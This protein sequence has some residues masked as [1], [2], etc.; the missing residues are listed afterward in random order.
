MAEAGRTL[1]HL[2]RQIAG[3]LKAAEIENAS[4]EARRIVAVAAGIEPLDIVAR[5]ETTVSEAA[6]AEIDRIATRRERHEPISRILGE[7]EFFGR[8]FAI[9]P[10]TLDPRPDTE[11]LIE[12]VLDLVGDRARPARLLDVGTGTGIIAITLL[13]ELPAATALA[14]DLS[15]DALATARRNAERLGV[16]ERLRLERRD[17]LDPGGWLGAAGAFDLIVSNPPYIRSGDI[18]GLAPEV[19]LFDPLLALDGGG[20]GLAAYRALRGYLAA[21]VPGGWIV[22]E[23][24]AGQVEDVRLLLGDG[25][26]NVRLDSDLGGHVRVVAVQPRAA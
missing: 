16:A 25:A 14:I 18:A 26:P 11:A 23:V 10:G 4:G 9:S 8:P 21:I 15:E 22:V 5:P 6:L 12:T 24:G 19:R 3:R 2:N 1:G 13:A 7:R 17:L 20:D